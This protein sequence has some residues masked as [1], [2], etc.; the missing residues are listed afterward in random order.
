[1]KFSAARAASWVQF[2]EGKFEVCSRVNSVEGMSQEIMELVLVGRIASF[3]GR[4][5]CEAWIP[6]PSI[7]AIH[8][9]PSAVEATACHE[10]AAAV[11][12]DQVVPEFVEK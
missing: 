8:L 11:E 1:M 5:V 7:A 9:P 12:G 10:A 4:V 3:G 6:P 2:V